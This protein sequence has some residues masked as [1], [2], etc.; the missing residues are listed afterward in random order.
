[1]LSLRLFFWSIRRFFSLIRW[2]LQAL[3][4]ASVRLS[5]I[6]LFLGG[7]IATGGYLVAS[8]YPS[9]LAMTWVPAS[10]TVILGV[11]ILVT[12][13]LGLYLQYILRPGLFGR[14]GAMMLM[15]GTLVLVTGAATLDIFILPWM[16]KLI[17]ELSGLNGQLQT[18]INHAM[19]GLNGATSSLGNACKN[20]QNTQ[21]SQMCSS[22]S[23]QS[24][25]HMNLPSIN[26]QSTVNKL[27]S[28]IGLAQL[29]SLKI[30]GLAFLSGAPLALGCLLLSLTFLRAGLKSRKALLIL[31]CCAFLNLGSTLPILGILFPS[32]LGGLLV[33]LGNFLL[34]HAAFLD[35]VSGVLLFLSISWLGFTLWSPWKLYIRLPW[36]DALLDA[37]VNI[38][39]PRGWFK[40]HSSG[41]VN[42]IS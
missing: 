6:L 15:L 37:K 13:M 38:L 34:S 28:E 23:S 40:R 7:L 17:G 42:K 10:W 11:L 4:Q 26:G 5:G 8:L 29:D 20:A 31:I 41:Q 39:R 12:G 27:L 24:I 9:P 19:S 33:Y 2:S 30:W 25:P 3:S 36:Q 16:F 22:T 14:T 1:M 21:I 18:S 32:L 35:S